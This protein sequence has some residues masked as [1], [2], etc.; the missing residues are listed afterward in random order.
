MADPWTAPDMQAAP[1]RRYVAFD[2]VIEN[3]IGSG[4][5]HYTA[6]RGFKLSDSQRFVY[7]P[8]S[9]KGN[10]G[11]DAVNL[12]PGERVAGWVV[13]EVGETSVVADLRYESRKLALPP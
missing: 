1:G 2:V 3:P 9:V 4:A 8:E 6:A 13:F 7:A 10:G 12:D 5:P 11:L